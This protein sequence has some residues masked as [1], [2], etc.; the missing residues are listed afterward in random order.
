MRDGSYT[1]SLSAWG[2]DLTPVVK[3]LVLA[4]VIVFVLQ[5]LLTRP[6]VQ[7]VPDFDGVWPDDEEVATDTERPA[8]KQDGPKSLTAGRGKR[9]PARRA[10]PW[11]RCSPAC[12]ACAPRLSRTGSTRP[13]EDRPAGTGLAAGD[14]RILP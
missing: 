3:Y 4:N 8:R 12:R 5:L 2:M 10:R 11:K 14:E 9:T 13:E 7:Q 1:A 6:V